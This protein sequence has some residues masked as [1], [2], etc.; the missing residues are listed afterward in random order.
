MKRKRTKQFFNQ[1]HR[2]GTIVLLT[3]LLSIISLNSVFSSELMAEK[4]HLNDYFFVDISGV[5]TD[6]NGEPLIGVNILVKGTSNGT[7]SDYEG[8]FMLEGVAPD[9]ILEFSYIGFQKI[10]IPVDNRSNIDV[11]LQS[12]AITMDEL[13]VVGYGTVKKSDLTGSVQRI[14]ADKFK[15]QSMTQITDMLTGSVAGF[16]ANQS[17]SA[18]GGSSLE[19]RGPTSLTANTEPLIVLDGVIYNGDLRDINPNDVETIDV[20]KDASSAAVYGSR[21][22]SGVI[23]ITTTK[24]RTGKP[25]INFSTK[26]GLSK[27][28]SDDYAVRGPEEYIDFRKAY[29]RGNVTSFPDE[30]W[31]DPTNLREGVSLEAWRALNPN[32]L[33]DDTREYLS[34]LNF[35]PTEIETYLAGETI[36]WFE[37]TMRTGLRQEYDLSINGG[38]DNSS[39]Y[40]SIGYVNNEGIIR[41]DEYG[42]I[43][44]RL[45]VDFKVTDWLNV[46]ANTQFSV[47]DE[48]AVTANLN[49]MQTTS[50]FARFREDDGSLKWYPGDYVGGQNPLINTLGQDRDRKL[51]NLFSSIYGKVTLP[52]GITYKLSYQPRIESLRDYN[53]WSP[54]TIIGGQDVSG[55]RANRTDFSRYEYMVDNL[56][57]WNRSFGDH[58]FDVT[59]LYNIEKNRSWQT[60]AVNNTFQPSPIL[61]YSGLQ[62]GI[63]PAIVTTDNIVTGDAKMARLNY[64]YKGKYLFTASVRRDGFSAFGQ[65]NPRATFPA[66]AFAW[67]ISD[68]DFF[69]IPAIDQAKLRLSYGVNGNRD[70]GAYAAL[71]QLS[72]DQYYDG[73]NVLIGV[74]TS[75]L[76]NPALVWEETKAFNIGLD[77]GILENRINVSIDYYDMKTNSLLVQR[78]LPRITGFSSVTT[79]I[80]ELGNKGFEFTINSVNLNSQNFSWRSAFN[81][82][83]NRNKI[84]S[85]F[86]ETGTYTLEGS[87][88]DGELPDFENEWFPGYAI[89]AIWNYDITGIWQVE[90]KDQAEVYGLEPGDLKAADLN[91]SGTYEALDDKKFIGYTQ[92]RVRLGFRN[93]FN[94]LQNF[95][96]A[97]FIRAD[98][99]HKGA[100]SPAI[101]RHS[102]YDRRNTAPVPYWTAE[103]RSNDWPRLGQNDAPYGGGIMVFKSRQFVRI[104]DVTLNYTFPSR[105]TQI[106]KFQSLRVFGSIRNLATFTKWPG[107]DPESGLT[108]MPK[109]YTVGL[110]MTL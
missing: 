70:I 40:W 21:A 38:T 75:T 25:T 22:A 79:N 17:T 47:R 16:N 31:D 72:P 69:D 53:Y 68:E 19:V 36:D 96:A 12:D 82:S 2:D 102:T 107:W 83:L 94:F 29:Y 108:P 33:P 65:L 30:Y 14:D 46:G 39:Y 58:D 5:V 49:G 52:F 91:N 26:L 10:E 109:T 106:A 87:Q 76:A 105:L 51:N 27:V 78:T 89:D 23:I 35:F 88:Y 42:V 62:F 55:G 110:N 59:L 15:D 9:A 104:Q 1:N 48:S 24:G 74:S 95:S 81:M 61:G 20:L 66:G 54:A 4:T 98:L 103:N 41:G 45:N 7:T 11:R 63:N 99:G 44:S 6:E 73:T 93:E 18:A 13:V 92:P 34:R 101:H 32:P 84:L 97:I 3:L 8:K 77:L 85:L 86:G 90:E 64:T 43:R 71:A 56:I 57:K 60:Y 28:T 80:G 100:F 37:K 67:K 50:P